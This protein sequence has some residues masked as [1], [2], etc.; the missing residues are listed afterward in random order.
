MT[1]SFHPT[2]RAFLASASALLAGPLAVSAWTNPAPR[3]RVLRIAHLTDVHVQPERNAAA[4]F[5]A[6]LHHVQNQADKPD[7]ILFGGDN[8]MD[9]FDQTRERTRI[10]WDVW[11]RVLKAECSLPYQSCI[12]NHDVWGWGPKSGAKP[13]DV[14]YGKAWAV[15]E[16]RLPRRFYGFEKAGWKFLVLDSTQPNPNRHGYD[17]R[18]DEEQFAWLT[19]EL[20][21]TLRTTPILILSH[22]PILAACAFLDGHNEKS[23]DWVVP[24]SWMH[25]DARKLTALFHQHGNVKVCLSGHMHLVDAVQYLGTTYYCNGAVCGGWWKG[26]NQQFAEGYALVDLYDDGTSTCE[27]VTYGWQA[28]PEK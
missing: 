12:G 14:G 13:E 1:Q 7:L 25:L 23:G 27:Y 10:Q 19:A 2:R 4:G 20:R 11:H 16:L 15:E 26:K 6:C 22:I 9:S 8:I 21:A 24:G 3:K 17:G 18:L 5:A 28:A